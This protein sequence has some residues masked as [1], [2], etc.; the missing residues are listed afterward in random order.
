MFLK[1]GDKIVNSEHIL[2]ISKDKGIEIMLDTQQDIKAYRGADDETLD[3]VIN[4]LY[5]AL[6]NKEDITDETI[7]KRLKIRKVG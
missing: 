2:A 7:A 5:D 3:E 6:V 4:V 1:L